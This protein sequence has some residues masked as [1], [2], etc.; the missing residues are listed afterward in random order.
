[1]RRYREYFECWATENGFPII[2]AL[3]AKNIAL[4]DWLGVFIGFLITLMTIIPAMKRYRRFIKRLETI[5]KLYDYLLWMI[6]FVADPSLAGVFAIIGISAADIGSLITLSPMV[7]HILF[8]QGC[9]R[10]PK[11]DSYLTRIVQTL[12]KV[13]ECPEKMKPLTAI[14]RVFATAFTFK[15]RAG[16]LEYFLA[17]L[18]CMVAIPA[19]GLSSGALVKALGIE[20]EAAIFAIAAIPTFILSTVAWFA[21]GVRRLHDLG[22]SGWHTMTFLLPFVVNLTIKPF[23][24]SGSNTKTALSIALVIF[25][26][27]WLVF[28]FFLLLYPGK[29]Q[30]TTTSPQETD[31]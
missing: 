5:K 24:V 26:F 2:L 7:S 16:R 6:A 21:A 13:L 31:G 11:P 29:K 10:P 8:V 19:I 15:G 25:G 22:L 12:P 9:I 28:W 30:N 20:V 3:C 27:I 14:R 23:A 4:T 18:I 1:M 17:N